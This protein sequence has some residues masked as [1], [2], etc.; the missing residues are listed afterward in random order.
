MPE[1]SASVAMSAPAAVL[2]TAW[3]AED[4]AGEVCRALPT[5]GD[6][7]TFEKCMLVQ[8]DMEGRKEEKENVWLMKGIVHH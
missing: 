1:S 5:A 2:C 3:G 8:E 7:A 6:L 4:L